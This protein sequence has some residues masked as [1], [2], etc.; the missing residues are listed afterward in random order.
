MSSSFGDFLKDK[1]FLGDL[2]SVKPAGAVFMVD[3]SCESQLSDLSLPDLET[4]SVYRNPLYIGT[5][6]KIK[7]GDKMTGCCPVG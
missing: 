3:F 5:I 1:D 2:E 7:S 4:A 6:C